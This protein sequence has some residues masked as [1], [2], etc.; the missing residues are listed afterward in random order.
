M[1]VSSDPARL[2]KLG[3]GSGADVK[4]LARRLYDAQRDH[5]AITRLTA[6]RPIDEVESYRKTPGDALD[7]PG[8]K[9]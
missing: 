1:S 3:G 9:K 4:S 2:D 8:K 6:E 7:V 5:R